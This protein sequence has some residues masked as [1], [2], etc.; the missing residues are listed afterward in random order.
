[1]YETGDFRKGLKIEFEGNPYVIV[2]FQHNADVIALENRIFK[3]IGASLNASEFYAAAGAVQAHDRT[4]RIIYDRATGE[5]YYDEDGSR[6]GHAAIHFATLSNVP[7]IDA[8]DF[9]IV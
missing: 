8:G 4:D 3:T 7:W 9:R 1:M 6:A 5:L 2:D